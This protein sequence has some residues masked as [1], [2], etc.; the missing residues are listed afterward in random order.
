[1]KVGDV[2]QVTADNSEYVY[3]G[4][5]WEKL[6]P[7]ID[8]SGY[9]TSISIAGENLTPSANTITA[10]QLKT[11]LGL[12][13]AAY[14]NT[15]S[16]LA[17]D[18]NLPT[19]AAVKSF[20]EG[21]GYTTNTGTVTKV[22][23]GTGLTG[24]DITTTGTIALDTS[25]VTAGSAGPTAAVTGT[26]GTTIAVPRITVD[27]YGRVTALT[28]Y[29]LTNKNTTYSSKTA[30]SGGTDVSLVTTGEKYTWNSKTSN[31]GTVT[32]VA[33][34]AGLTGGTITGSG[35][36]KA[37]L[38]SETK[39]SLASAAMGSTASRQ[40]AV[41]L[42]SSGYL[43]VNVPWTDTNTHTI[44]G[45]KGNAES[46]YRT[47]NVNLTPAN[48]GAVNKTG[49]TM[50]GRLI[51][52]QGSAVHSAIGTSGT[53]GT[54]RI[55]QIKITST[56]INAPIEI[57]FTRRTDTDPTILYI[58]FNSGNTTDPTLNTFKYFGSC[59]DVW[60]YK[61]STSTWGLYIAKSE[62]YDT[63]SVTD[64]RIPEYLVSR[65]TLTWE[66]T[67]ATPSSTTYYAHNYNPLLQIGGSMS[68]A[69]NMNNNQL[70]LY[71]SGTSY[72][73][74]W[75][76]GTGSGNWTM[77]VN[78]SY[79]RSVTNDYLN[80]ESNHIQCRNPADTAW[81]SIGASAFNTQSS[82]RYKE[83]ISPVTEDRAEKL[84]DVEVV[85]Y[86]YKDGVMDD[87]SKQF[88]RIGVIAEDVISVIP[89]VV[90]KRE[91]DGVEVP[92]GVDYAQFVPYL[93]KIVQMQDKK[94]KDL[95]EKINEIN[96]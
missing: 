43:S 45:V 95:E 3:N 80:L 70:Y 89:E 55:A 21:K 94:I 66:N 73:G 83:N 28:S 18:G 19:G 14:V 10:A 79:G 92:D 29:N 37:A 58:L 60:L 6:G 82:K 77:H 27:A 25:G 8:L 86:D 85:N 65:I 31:T 96:T 88:N 61:I 36:L 33:T 26:E 90:T 7:T 23:A 68:G 13:S 69:I 76:D 93:I 78:A 34:G 2:W 32:S 71:Q 56:Y 75:N 74:I 84:L 64:V 20:V 50:T 40:Y 62:A 15:E 46:S 48:I 51:L 44:T 35:T 53:A 12:G 52:Q 47:G 49:D 57:K 81:T 67:Q 72:S 11:A 42:D 30:A 9:L 91:I 38:K 87:K 1:M 39:S 16:T 24:G 22:T 5:T 17:N 54:V 59:A 41:G 63:I 4:T